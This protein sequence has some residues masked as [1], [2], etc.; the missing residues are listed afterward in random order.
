MWTCS[1]KSSK[2]ASFSASRP[3]QHCPEIAAEEA[4]RQRD[5]R[6]IHQRPQGI[7]AAHRRSDHRQRHRRDQAEGHS[8]DDAAGVEAPPEQR[9]NQHREVGARRNADCKITST[10]TLTPCARMP[11]TIASRPIGNRR[12]TCNHDLLLRI[13]FSLLHPVSVEVVRDGARCRQCKAPR[14]LRG[15]SQPQP[16][17]RNPASD[18]R[19]RCL[20][21]RRGGCA[22]SGSVRLPPRAGRLDRILSDVSSL[23]RYRTTLFRQRRVLPETSPTPLSGAPS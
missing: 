2:R 7:R 22:S 18:R 9:Q 16:P 11:S 5:D 20:C 15:W 21:R 1:E 23:Q 3:V 8:A 14:P 12:N 13:G 6:R 10:A 4:E 17:Q 19:R